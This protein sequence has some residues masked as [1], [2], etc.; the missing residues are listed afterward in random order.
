MTS[1]VITNI[2]DD[3]L[4]IDSVWIEPKEQ[5][6]VSH[7]SPDML[8]AQAAHKLRIL[9]A[10]TTLAERKADTAAIKPF[11]VGDPAIDG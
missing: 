4:P 5:L 3:P 1:F 8:A 10:D 6:S 11:K 7:L 9:S 2:S